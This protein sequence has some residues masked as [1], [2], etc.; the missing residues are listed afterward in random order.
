ML[1]NSPTLRLMVILIDYPQL[2]PGSDEHDQQQYSQSDGACGG[3]HSHVNPKSVSGTE[4]GKLYRVAAA[5]ETCAS[6]IS[7]DCT[8]SSE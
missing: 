5:Q 4:R 7:S 2:R 8:Q 1:I 3:K 6:I